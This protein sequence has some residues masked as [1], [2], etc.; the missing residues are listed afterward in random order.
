[1]CILCISRKLIECFL[2]INKQPDFSLKVTCICIPLSD[3]L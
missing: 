2:L 1:M 3:M